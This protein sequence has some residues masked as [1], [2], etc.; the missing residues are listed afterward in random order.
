MSQEKNQANA[1]RIN[2]W[3][4]HQTDQ[5][6]PRDDFIITLH[7]NIFYCDTTKSP[8]RQFLNRHR[9][10]SHDCQYTTV[11]A[12]PTH[13]PLLSNSCV[14]LC[15]CP[16]K[17]VTNPNLVYSHIQSR[18]NIIR[19]CFSNHVSFGASSAKSKFSINFSNT[20]RTANDPGRPNSA[21]L[22]EFGVWRNLPKYG[23]HSD[24]RSE[25]RFIWHDDKE[26]KIETSD[27]YRRW[28]ERKNKACYTSEMSEKWSVN[29]VYILFWY[30]NS[31]KPVKV[32]ARYNCLRSLGRW[33]SHYRH[34]CLLCVY[35][36]SVSVLSCV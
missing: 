12:Y 18:D 24:I 25:I 16:M 23:Q 8:I 14:S 3:L 28:F 21:V 20:P 2:L 27:M 4:K 31:D 15:V 22:T 5:D 11:T 13:F 26:P 10:S 7:W 9:L 30:P 29:Q 36:Y 1:L 17:P 6:G 34:G 35:V 33:E 19:Q 32:A